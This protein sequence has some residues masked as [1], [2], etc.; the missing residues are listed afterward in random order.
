MINK[1][2]N[3]NK[4]NDLERL[5]SAKNNRA[6]YEKFLKLHE[7]KTK[8]YYQAMKD[9]RLKL[10]DQGMKIDLRPRKFFSTMKVEII[11]LTFG[12]GFAISN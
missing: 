8:K 10:T 9:E 5:N 12:I 11:L 7:S 2:K 6:F 3:S 4:S 1:D